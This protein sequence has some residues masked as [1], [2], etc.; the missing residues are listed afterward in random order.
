MSL[1][2]W[3]DYIRLTLLALVAYATERNFFQKTGEAETPRSFGSF[4]LLLC[5][6]LG[7]GNS[8]LLGR[9]GAILIADEV[10]GE[11]AAGLGHG[12]QVDGVAAH[13][14]HGDLGS[15][16]LVAVTGGIHTHDTAPALV[17]V[18]D[19]IAHVVIGHSDLQFTHGLQQHGVGLGQSGLV[20]QLSGGLERN[21]GGVHGVIGAIGVLRYYLLFTAI[22]S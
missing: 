22:L 18:A 6:R 21:F 3:Y 11:A 10:E 1:S 14:A 7:L 20:G 8:L 5:Q 19:D 4:L 15:D 2:G 17:Q 12:P 13:L 9:G 16:D